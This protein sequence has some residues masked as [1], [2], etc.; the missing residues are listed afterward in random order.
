LKK[1]NLSSIER[2]DYNTSTITGGILKHIKKNIEKKRCL[3]I[4]YKE[5]NDYKMLEFYLPQDQ[6]TET[7][8]E[9]Y[10]KLT[11]YIRFKTSQQL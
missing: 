9:F 2:I 8:E 5:S 10:Q 4:K 1:I 3:V 6:K 7:L 11:N